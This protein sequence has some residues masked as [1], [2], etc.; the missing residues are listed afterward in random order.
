VRID[1]LSRSHPV[2]VLGALLAG[3]QPDAARVDATP[4]PEPEL[5][6]LAAQLASRR[7]RAAAPRR[8]ATTGG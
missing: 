5:R 8:S 4:E 7:R 3:R 1:D 2:S 6:R